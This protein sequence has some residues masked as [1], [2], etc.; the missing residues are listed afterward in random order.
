MTPAQPLVPMI[1]WM[2][3]RV[4]CELALALDDSETALTIVERQAR[5]VERALPDGIEPSLEWARGRALAALGRGSEAEQVF[6]A[7]LDFSQTHRARPIHWRIHL[8]LGS[9]LRAE[10]RDDEAERELAAARALVDAIAA[11]VPDEPTN[12]GD[13]STLRARFAAGASALFPAARR[14]TP[15]RAAKLA[16]DGLTA[17]EREVAVL[18]AAGHSNRQIAEALNVSE[19][20]V[21]THVTSMLAK[22]GASSRVQIAAWAVEKRLVGRRG[23]VAT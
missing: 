14:L 23:T 13:G 18:I 15:L 1:E 9:L 22:L 10:E 6:R 8:A 11:G 5:W 3:G 16:H 4:R 17:R 19:R 12:E 21:T 7:A 2:D 20:T